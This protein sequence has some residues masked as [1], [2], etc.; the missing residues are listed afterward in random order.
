MNIYIQEKLLRDLETGMAE[1]RVYVKM[2]KEDVR[3]YV[4]WIQERLIDL[5]FS[6]GTCG[7]DGDFGYCTLVA[8]QNFQ[9]NNGLASDGKVRQSTLQM[10]LE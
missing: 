8:V 3:E 4:K 7:A 5:G 6:C 10:L 1:A 2:I 9:A